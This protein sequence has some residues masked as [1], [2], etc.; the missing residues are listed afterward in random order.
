MFPLVV[1]VIRFLSSFVLFVELAGSTPFPAQ[2][3]GYHLVVLVD[4]G[5]SPSLNQSSLSPLS[6]APIYRL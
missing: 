5:H 6:L 2:L 3:F 1:V 4:L